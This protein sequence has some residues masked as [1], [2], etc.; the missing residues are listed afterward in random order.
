MA[1][2]LYAKLPLLLLILLASCANPYRQF[3]RPSPGLENARNHSAYD[4]SATGLAVY[5]TDNFDRD[6]AILYSQSYWPIGSSSFSAGA[7][8]ITEANLRSQ[9]RMVG[10]HAVLIKSSYSHTVQGAIPINVPQTSTTYSSGTATAYGRGGYATAY[11]TGKSTTYSSQT[12]MTP[13]SVA[14]Y[15]VGA[16]FFAKIKHRL[17]IVAFP[18]KDEDRRKLQ[19]NAGVIVVAVAEETPAFFADIFAGDYLIEVAGEKIY[20]S[21]AFRQILDKHE[22]VEVELLLV[23]DG[24]KIRKLVKILDIHSPKSAK[25]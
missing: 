25:Q 18:L 8:L 22:G 3:Y 1:I 21:K 4:S 19:S 13:Y 24:K 14:R 20:S 5:T 23:R 16:L 7:S 17:G 11:G 2:K 10:A 9:A 6:T 15:E 12:V